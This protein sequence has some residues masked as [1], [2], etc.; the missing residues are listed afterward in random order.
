MVENIS[1][2]MVVLQAYGIPVVYLHAAVKRKPIVQPVVIVHIR[3]V[4]G[5]Q[6]AVR[7]IVHSVHLKYLRWR[8]DP[9]CGIGAGSN[10]QAGHER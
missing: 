10:H 7:V 8:I 6:G 1:Q 5:I 9:A 3:A 4:P 2:A